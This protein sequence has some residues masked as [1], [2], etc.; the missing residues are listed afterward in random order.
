MGSKVIWTVMV[1]GDEI[2]FLCFAGVNKWLWK[3][4]LFPSFSI[5]LNLKIKVTKKIYNS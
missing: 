3:G 5:S 2:G 4:F 1:A